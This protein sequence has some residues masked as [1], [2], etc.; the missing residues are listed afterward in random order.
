ML[1]NYIEQ[2]YSFNIGE[3]NFI[4]P[5]VLK[6]TKTIYIQIKEYVNKE[7][8]KINFMALLYIAL[9]NLSNDFNKYINKHKT[10]SKKLQGNCE[11]LLN[12]TMISSNGLFAFLE[13]LNKIFSKLNLDPK[14]IEI[15][16]IQNLSEIQDLTMLL[17]TVEKDVADKGNTSVIDNTNKAN[18][19]EEKKLTIEYF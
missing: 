1:E 13:I 3:I 15:M 9:N 12:N 17:D 18:K 7:D 14:N 8:K 4:T 10:N 6:P 5:K 2:T 16:N 11:K 19:K